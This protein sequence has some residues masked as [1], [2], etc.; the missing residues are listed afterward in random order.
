[1]KI[2]IICPLYNAEKYINNLHKSFLMQKN[3]D[4]LTITYI[5]TKSNDNTQTIL[6][7]FGATY[8]LIE[9]SEFSHS[10]TREKAAMS[11][12]ADI[13]VFVT[14][15]VIIKRDDWLI[16]LV[17]GIYNGDYAASY[18]RQ[19]CTNNSIEKYTRENNYPS[20]SFIVSRDDISKRGLKTF[21]F[22]DA[23]GAIDLKIFKELKGY[24]SK[25]LPISED[26]YFAY[27]LIMN[28]YKIGYCADSEVE[29]SHNFSFKELYNRYFLTG[30]FFRQNPYLD[31]YDT[32]E[33]GLKMAAYIFKSA[34]KEGNMKAL[35]EFFPNMIARYLGMKRGKQ[36]E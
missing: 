1:M 8:S 17:D 18:S 12:N 20:Q 29:H 11:S 19:L 31:Q 21:F 10:L 2:E 24:D 5:L 28:G 6:N 33:S 23:A 35:K 27:K 34:I 4:D 26:M 7:K 15:D 14:Q 9:P 32:T 25:E 16:N 22:S 13:I 30:Q 36:S 3:V